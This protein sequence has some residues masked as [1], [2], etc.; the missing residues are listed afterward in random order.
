MTENLATFDDRWTMRH[1]RW[2][3]HP[4]ELVWEAVTTPAHLDVWLA[5]ASGVEIEPRVGGRCVFQFGGPNPEV[6]NWSPAVGTVTVFDPP[7]VVEYDLGG[8]SLRFEM[9]H[10]AGGTR[11]FFVHGFEPSFR[12]DQTAVPAANKEWDL[13]AGPDTPWRPG[14]C[15]GFHGM[16][17]H[18]VDMLDG[19]WS[20][21]DARP[22]IEAIRSGGSAHDVLGTAEGESHGDPNLVAGYASHIRET[23]PEPTG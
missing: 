22:Y 5:P 4:P 6:R 9:E 17:D 7:K 19:R 11:L 2:F 15:A 23:C 8:S 14:F 10:E 21:E 16:L 3:P 12:Q 20:Y 1:T 18:L 13:P